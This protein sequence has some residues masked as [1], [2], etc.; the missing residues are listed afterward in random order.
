MSGHV[1]MHSRRKEEANRGLSG[2]ACGL[3]LPAW[4]CQPVARAPR[5]GGT[6]SRAQQTVRL[7]LVPPLSC[8]FVFI[9]LASFLAFC[10]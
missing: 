5:P 7:L 4:P 3:A 10:F 1:C 2:G 6:E 9:F 8:F